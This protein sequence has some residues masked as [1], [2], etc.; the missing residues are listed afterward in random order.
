MVPGV[1][2]IIGK[3]FEWIWKCF[4][5]EIVEASTGRLERKWKEF[6]F[7]YCRHF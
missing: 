6:E 4:G 3:T 1:E 2:V 5:K 7:Q